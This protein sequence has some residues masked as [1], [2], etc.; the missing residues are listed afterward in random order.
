MDKRDYIYIYDKNGKKQKMELVLVVNKEGA[1][2]KYIVYK[3]VNK[4][5]PLYMAK[6][7]L[8]EGITK[9]D[10]NL[11]EDEKDMLINIIKKDLLEEK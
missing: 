3:N 6:L 7:K 5:V 11:Q 10:T 1:D 9:L 8:E 2:Y 4:K